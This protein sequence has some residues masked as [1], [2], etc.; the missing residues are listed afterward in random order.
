VSR[1]N[2]HSNPARRLPWWRS[3]R[4]LGLIASTFAVA[5]ALALV[6][7]VGGRS[8]VA[9]ISPV[10][11][12]VFYT[13]GAA[14]SLSSLPPG[15]MPGIV[16][17]NLTDPAGVAVAGDT[18]FYTVDSFAGRGG[19]VLAVPV[20][21]PNTAP[22]VVLSGLNNPSALAADDGA[23]RLYVAELGGTVRA[24]NLSDGT[25]TVVVPALPS[26]V[27]IVIIGGTL[28]IADNVLN[29]VYS[30]P[31]N[32]GIP[33]PLLTVVTTPSALATDGTMLYV[34][35]RDAGSIVSVP[36][37]APVATPTTIVTG[38]NHPEGLE[39][40]CCVLYIGQQNGTLLRFQ[41][42]SGVQNVVAQTA[43]A[44]HHIAVSRT[45]NV[46]ALPGITTSTTTTTTTT[47]PPTT[48]CPVPGSGNGSEGSNGSGDG[49]FGSRG[50]VQNDNGSAGRSGSAD[51]ENGSAGSVD[52]C[53]GS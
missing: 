34:A 31:E 3:N 20:S 40:D 18:L 29:L 19:A 48:T 43:S 22:Q 11:P 2:D 26:A 1:T 45:D 44:I 14:G 46:P 8:D 49:G 13:S 23:Q 39:F 51:S 36:A 33:L 7:V 47:L 28:Y 5:L 25:S 41:P 12:T 15:G 37:G 17:S 10:T 30:V 35:Q 32:G 27:D 42:S 53:T 4:A 9:A 24:I 50:N 38:L 16:T 6:V 21:A 52:D